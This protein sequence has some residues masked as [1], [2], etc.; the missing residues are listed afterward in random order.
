[1]NPVQAL[2]RYGYAIVPAVVPTSECERMADALD[3]LEHEQREAGDRAVRDDE[4]VVIYCADVLNPDLFLP[5][6]NQPLVTDV[7]SK[8]LSTPYVLSSCAGSRSGPKGGMR[9]HIDGRIPLRDFADTTH[10]SAVFCLDDFT[11]ASGAIQ[12]WPMSHTTGSAPPRGVASDALP[13][14]VDC[15]AA[16]GS[17]LF[18]LGSTWHEV[19]NNS[20]GKRRWGLIVTYCRW[21]VKPTYD[22]TKCGPDAYGRLSPAQRALYGFTS[23]PPGPRE[24]RHLTL[25][26]ADDL[27]DSYPA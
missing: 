21:W 19:G 1:M 4:Q 20:S 17:V 13:G 10:L 3:A 25:T 14:R 5:Y 11:Q 26:R 27:P 23:K 2:E 6:V 22:Y 7:A 16:R 18:F 9:P 12:F 8:V 15:E 24:K